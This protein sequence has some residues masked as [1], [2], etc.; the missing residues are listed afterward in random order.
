MFIL[1]NAITCFDVGVLHHVSTCFDTG[2]PVCEYCPAYRHLPA[3]FMVLTPCLYAEA[4]CVVA[5]VY[6]FTR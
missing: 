3:M 1:H 6:A 5:A 4:T 2:L